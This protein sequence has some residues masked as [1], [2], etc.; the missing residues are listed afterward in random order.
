MKK[1]L[2]ISF[3]C[4]CLCG[5]DNNDIKEYKCIAEKENFNEGIMIRT[6]TI[7]IKCKNNE[8]ISHTDIFDMIYY[9]STVAELSLMKFKNED[10]YQNCELIGSTT[11][12][13]ELKQDI[14][15]A[16]DCDTLVDNYK[17]IMN[18]E[19]KEIK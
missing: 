1:I 3:F 18:A 6:D 19:C 10:R 14:S 16:N 13:C 9:D 2:L 12:S 11:L 15:N 7:S 4:L 5:C 17:N 8:V